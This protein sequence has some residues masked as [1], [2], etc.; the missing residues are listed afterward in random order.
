MSNESRINEIADLV[1][2]LQQKQKE[3]N[4]LWLL[5]YKLM[6]KLFIRSC[7]RALNVSQTPIKHGAIINSMYKIVLL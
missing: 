3:V 2:K 4:K 1:N 5:I 6:K 7:A